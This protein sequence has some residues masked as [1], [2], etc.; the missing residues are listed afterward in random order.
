MTPEQLDCLDDLILSG[1]LSVDHQFGYVF[2]IPSTKDR[3][4]FDEHLIHCLIHSDDD[5]LRFPKSGDRHSYTITGSIT[6]RDLLDL[7]PEQFLTDLTRIDSVLEELSED[8]LTELLEA[9]EYGKHRDDTDNVQLYYKPSGGRLH[10]RFSGIHHGEIMDQDA[11]AEYIRQTQPNQDT[12]LDIIYQQPY[13]PATHLGVYLLGTI[14]RNTLTVEYHD[15]ATM[16]FTYQDHQETYL[17]HLE[18]IDWVVE[19]DGHPLSFKDT[20]DHFIERSISCQ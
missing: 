16:T 5:T 4:Y 19:V 7:M 11:I 15:N 9:V 10:S 3:I 1:K 13:A 20:L 6:K 2:Q 14:G 12:S 18:L 17:V 8:T